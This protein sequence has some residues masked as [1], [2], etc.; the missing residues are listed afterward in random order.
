MSWHPGG[1]KLWSYLK[2]HEVKILSAPSKRV[3]LD[4]IKGKKMWCTSLGNPEIIF[5]SKEKKREFAKK[6]AILID[7]LKSNIRDW[8]SSGG[9]GIHHTNVN[10]TIAELKEL[11][12]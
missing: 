12:L 1:K 9:V 4:C 10:K 11:G 8:K 7:D 6:N 3:V 2:K 5:R